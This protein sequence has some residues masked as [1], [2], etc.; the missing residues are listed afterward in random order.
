V[1]EYTIKINELR[2]GK[3]E[4]MYKFRVAGDKKKAKAEAIAILKRYKK[5]YPYGIFFGI[6]YV[7]DGKHWRQDSGI[8]EI[9]L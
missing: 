1:K 9:R 4:L 3:H 6:P 5:L 7:K 2:G 8:G